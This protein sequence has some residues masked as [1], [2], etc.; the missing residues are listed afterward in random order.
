VKKLNTVFYHVSTRYEIGVNILNEPLVS[1]CG[2]QPEEKGLLSSSI[3]ASAVQ[4][5]FWIAGGR[6][7]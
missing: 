7:E 2:A 3:K 6:Y 5:S 1:E 4:I